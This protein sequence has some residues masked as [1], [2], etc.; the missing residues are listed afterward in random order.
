MDKPLQYFLIIS[1]V[2]IFLVGVF[3]WGTWTSNSDIP[4][5]YAVVDENDSRMV[6]AKKQAAATLDTFFALFPQHSDSTFARFSF[7]PTR[8]HIEHLWGKVIAL[9]SARVTVAL[10]RK[11]GLGDQYYP[12]RLE[13]PVNRIEDWLIHLENGSVRGGFTAQ[14]LLQKEEEKPAV[15]R[16]SLQRQLEKFSDRLE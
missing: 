9:D 1:A 10:K 5:E 14:A 6:L 13:L 12:E 11:E 3:V 8:N 15:N 16:D 4:N 7:E 2:F